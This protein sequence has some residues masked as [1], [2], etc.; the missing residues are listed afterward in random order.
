MS[1]AKH[2]PGTWTVSELGASGE[3]SEDYIFIE[4]GVAVIERKVA[5]SDQ[6]D[7]PDAHLI[8]AA[9]EMLEALVWIESHTHGFLTA[10]GAG[11]EFT[12][13]VQS[14]RAAIAKANGGAA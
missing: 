10:H 11:P 5:G 8:S 13:W 1:A 12:S 7:M 3:P 4:P 14:A 2:T 6:C 9:K